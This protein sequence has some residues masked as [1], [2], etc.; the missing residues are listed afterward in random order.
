MY[1]ENRSR[2]PRGSKMRS[3][4]KPGKDGGVA[5]SFLPSPP[6]RRRRPRAGRAA[7]SRGALSRAARRRPPAAAARPA[8]VRR[9]EVGPRSWAPRPRPGAAT[10]AARAPPFSCAASRAPASAGR[11]E[12]ESGAGARRFFLRLRG[13]AVSSSDAVAMDARGNSL[14]GLPML[15]RWKTGS[16]SRAPRNAKT[17]VAS[18]ML[19]SVR[20]AC[21]SEGDPRV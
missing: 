17:A 19:P 15:R 1:A 5:D 9:L 13:G 6:R 21:E 14:P 18:T 2:I 4:A 16:A 3:T 12:S 11:W 8:V 20:S 7:A 10:A